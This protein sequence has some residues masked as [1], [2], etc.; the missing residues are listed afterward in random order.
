[1][2]IINFYGMLLIQSKQLREES[3]T[4]KSIQNIGKTLNLPRHTVGSI[5][6]VEVSERGNY[7]R[8]PPDS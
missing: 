7:H 6:E 8:L 3:C 2:L 4:K 5:L 1:M